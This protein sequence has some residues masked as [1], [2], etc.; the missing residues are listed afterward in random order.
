VLTDTP[1]NP[2]AVKRQHSP[3]NPGMP[4]MGPTLSPSFA[5]GVVQQ[6]IFRL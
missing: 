3:G 6:Q 1:I 4:K 5:L 2:R